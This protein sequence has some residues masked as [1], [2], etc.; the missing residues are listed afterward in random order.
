MTAADGLS[1]T[2]RLGLHHPDKQAR[3]CVTC[4]RRVYDTLAGWTTTAPYRVTLTVEEQRKRLITLQTLAALNAE[5]GGD[6][7]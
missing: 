6:A 1:C 3:L 2:G 4:H 7:S 5:L